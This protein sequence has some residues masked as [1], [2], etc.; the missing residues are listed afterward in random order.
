[1]FDEAV[2]VNG[3]DLAPL[4]TK[5]LADQPILK[6][7]EQGEL[8]RLSKVPSGPKY[9]S[10]TAV[11]W[12]RSSNWMTR[13]LGWDR[14]LSETLALSVKSTRYGCERAGGHGVYSRAAYG[15]LHKKF[16]KE[17]R[18]AATPYWFDC[19]GF[20]LGCVGPYSQTNFP[21][22]PSS[23]TQPA[24]DKLKADKDD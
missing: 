20:R 22:P 7:A 5:I 21:Y 1:L 18:A 13:L 23:A 19:D 24:G 3:D 9:L 15:E 16:P 10:E 17:P 14:G 6:L 8:D 2:G 4:R 11:L 12:A